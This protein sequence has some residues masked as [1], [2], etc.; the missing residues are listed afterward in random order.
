MEDRHP[1]AGPP[2]QQLGAVEQ[3]PMSSPRRAGSTTRG[4]LG[5]S[6]QKILK[7]TSAASLRRR[8][9]FQILDELA[10]EDGSDAERQVRDQPIVRNA[11]RSK[12][13]ARAARPSDDFVSR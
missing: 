8:P 10:L 6:V 1:R 12:V 2:G 5:G 3:S 4:C 7:K 11:A 9:S 13:R